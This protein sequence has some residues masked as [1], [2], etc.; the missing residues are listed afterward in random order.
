MQACLLNS[1]VHC[2]LFY[3]SAKHSFY[4]FIMLHKPGCNGFLKTQQIFVF[5]KNKNCTLLFVE[6][7]KRFN[8]VFCSLNK[9][10]Y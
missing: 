2:S 9:V 10:A 1:A 6:Q 3:I 8:C 7:Q 5:K 4:L